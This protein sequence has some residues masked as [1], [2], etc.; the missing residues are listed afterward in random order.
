MA[1]PRL[2]DQEIIA[3]E[4][5]LDL[6]DENGGNESVILEHIDFQSGPHQ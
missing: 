1:V 2:E 3:V 5:E 6:D 4:E